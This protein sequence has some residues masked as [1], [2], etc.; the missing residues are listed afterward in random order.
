MALALQQE[1]LVWQKV[2]IALAN[3]KPD[4]Q[5][6]FKALREYLATHKNLPDLQF[7]PFT[8]ADTEGAAGKEAIFS[9]AGTLYGAYALCNPLRADATA[10]FFQITDAA[11]NDTSTT[12][13]NLLT[14]KMTVVGQHIVAIW[15]DGI[16]FATDMTIAAVTAIGGG[17][18]VGAGD[19][20]VGF[21]I[22]G[23]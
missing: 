9:A 20:M 3:A 1:G 16:P 21:V 10:A 22:V 8:A 12:A 11:D 7:V 6:A 5:L 14:S 19:G 17:T 2:K 18:A 15:G 4:A 23:A 13:G